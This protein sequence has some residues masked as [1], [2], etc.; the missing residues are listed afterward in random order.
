MCH[1]K[2]PVCKSSKISQKK[3]QKWSKN[4][5]VISFTYHVLSMTVDDTLFWVCYDVGGLFLLF[6]DD[7]IKC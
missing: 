1:I 7:N 4:L 3:I 6:L 2:V 5:G